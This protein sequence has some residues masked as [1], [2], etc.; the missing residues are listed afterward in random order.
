MSDDTPRI[1]NPESRS[2]TDPQD[3]L[4]DVLDAD[5][6]P[7]GLAKPRGEVHRDGDW[8]GALHIWVGGIGDDGV[9]FVLFQRRSLTK[10]TW[11]G[12]LDTAIGGHIR[13]GE[14]LE[15]TVREAEEEIGLE[16][17]L[18]DLTFIG[19]R[20]IAGSDGVVS[21]REI[22]SVYAVRC[23]RPLSDYRLHPEEVAGLVAIPLDAA[24]R[25]FA[26]DTDVV[27]GYQCL[28]DG[29][30]FDVALS[31]DEFV[32]LDVKYQLAALPALGAVING[33]I[34]EP[35]EVR[36]TIDNPNVG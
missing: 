6:R 4:F 31:R 7:T 17:G 12:F 8:H 26:G 36:T 21:E 9:P 25:V 29:E 28:C 10:D 27:V 14:T 22:H 3:E 24:Q 34:P 20:F 30:P 11:P 23:D 33:E 1:P 16:V 32:M 19:R 5:G 13:S 15:E 2:T 35:F 18:A